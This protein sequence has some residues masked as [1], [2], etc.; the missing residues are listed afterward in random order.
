VRS[1]QHLAVRVALFGA[2]FLAAG[3]F[4]PKIASNVFACGDGGACPD[5]FFC[6]LATNRCLDHRTDAGAPGGKG[7]AGGVGGVGGQGGRDAGVDHPCLPAVANANCPSD[8]GTNGLCDPVC[9]SRCPCFEKCSVDTQGD[10]TCNQPFMPPQGQVGLLAFCSQYAQVSDPTTQADNCA[11]GQIC[12][13]ASA[14]SPGPRCYQFCRNDSDCPGGATCSRDGGAYKFC[15]VPP[16]ACNPLRSASANPGCDQG[17]SCYLSTTGA[18]TLCDCQFDRSGLMT[19]TGGPGSDCNH[20]RDCLDGNV[21]V[22]SLGFGKG[23]CEPVCLLPVDG[24]AADT[25]IGG[26]QVIPGGTGTVYGYC[27]N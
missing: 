23:T 12:L 1:A 4:R 20:S 17:F 15:D 6:D 13:N 27:H 26:C 16:K 21:C 2:I 22:Q 10:L 7:G 25:C 8:A 19:G 3:C 18:N 5:N 11:P 14:C 24:G 9:N